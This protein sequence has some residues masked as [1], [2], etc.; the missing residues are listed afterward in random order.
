MKKRYPTGF[1]NLF[2]D[3]GIIGEIQSETNRYAK[4]QINV[5]KQQNPLKPKFI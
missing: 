3:N 4:K 1:L 2:F 5:K